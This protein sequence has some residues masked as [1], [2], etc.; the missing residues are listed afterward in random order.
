MKKLTF[1]IKGMHCASCVMLIEGDLEDLKGI[2][3]AKANLGKLQAEVEFDETVVTPNKIIEVIK[4]TG[5]QA[6][7]KD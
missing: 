4:E 7:I 2:Q 6:Q 5:Y 1:N 3:S